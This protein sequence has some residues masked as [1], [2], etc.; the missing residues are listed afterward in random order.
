[1][2]FALGGVLLGLVL[3]ARHALEPDHLAAMSLLVAD[4]RRPSR[5]LMIGA[6]WGAGHTAALLV[7]GLALAALSTTMPERLADA[8]ELGVAAMLVGLGSRAVWLAWQL[9]RT[10]PSSVHRH[11]ALEHRHAGPDSHVHLGRWTL[12]TRPLLVGMVHGLAGSGALTAL[13]V[14]KL[15]TLPLRL[16]FI[17]L[18]GIG[19]ILGMAALSGAIGWPLARLGRRPLT[20]RLLFAAAGAGSALLGLRWAWPLAA[21]LLS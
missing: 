14:A 3:G 8:F 6:F 13:V 11:G 12:A 20:A 2:S 7:A 18:F 9:A 1:M 4:A 21:R 10:G 15:P 17:T 5:T 16:A 19:S